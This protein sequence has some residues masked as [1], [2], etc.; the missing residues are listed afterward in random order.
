MKGYLEYLE[1]Y[2]YFARTGEPKLSR[3]D[4]EAAAAEWRDLGARIAE[5]GPEER[6]RLRELKALLY[7]D[8]P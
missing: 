2:D 6:A 3:D 5:L 1:L 8:K 4:F 7:R